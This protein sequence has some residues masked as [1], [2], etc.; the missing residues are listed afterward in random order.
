MRS[1][2]R[3]RAILMSLKG[4]P[5]TP[6]YTPRR[7][8]DRKGAKC[9]EQKAQPIYFFVI[10]TPSFF[11]PSHTVIPKPSPFQDACNGN[12]PMSFHPKFLSTFNTIFSRFSI[13]FSTPITIFY[14]FFCWWFLSEFFYCD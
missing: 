9:R 14:I 13:W 6:C 4:E 2:E 1:C 10:C 5:H 3:K 11:N 12:Q 7:A 8:S